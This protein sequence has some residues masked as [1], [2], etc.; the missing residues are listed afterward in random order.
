MQ[1]TE[2]NNLIWFVAVVDYQSFS[3]VAEKFNVSKSVISKYITQLEQRLGVQLLKRT[4]RRL[5]LTE[6][7]ELIYQRAKNISEQVHELKQLAYSQQ[8][9]PQG[10]LRVNAPFGFGQR[11]LVQVTAAFM[12]QYPQ[13]RVELI[14]GSYLSDLVSDGIDLAI[15]LKK[16]LNPNL[17]LRKIS[18]YHM[19]LCATR[20]YLEKHGEPKVPE[21]LLQHNCLVYKTLDHTKP[22]IFINHQG[23]PV[24]IAINGNFSANSSQALLSAALNHLGIVKLSSHIVSQYVE[25]G[26]LVLLLDAYCQKDVDIYVGRAKTSYLPKKQRLYIDFILKHLSLMTMHAAPS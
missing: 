2:V 17:V 10:R 21:D 20:D 25:K 5:C 12:L 11:H 24:E 18:S 8:D 23:T 6:I 16:P 1:N 3:A 7:G 9:N 19:C 13:I 22:W 4:T 26:Q 15:Y 14:L